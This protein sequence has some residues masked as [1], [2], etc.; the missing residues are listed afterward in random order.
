MAISVLIL[1][2]NEEQD[3][4]A[5]LDSIRWSTD[6]HVLDSFS[7]DRTVEI[8]QQAG[9]IVT[10]RRFDDW[11]TH[12]NWALLNLPFKF[13]WV[14][15][16]DADERVSSE[17][18]QNAN[19]QV[20]TSDPIS[21]FQIQR[22]DF[23]IDG[24]WLKHAQISPFYLRLF[25]PDK[26]RYE[27]LVNPVTIV[28]GP[29]RE[30]DGFLDHYPFSKGI[31]FWLERHINYSS[32]EASMIVDGQ[33]KTSS[34]SIFKG[35][36]TRDFTVRRYNQKAM[37]YKLPFRPLIK[38][39]YM[40]FWRRAFLDGKAGTTYAFL[41]SFYEYMIV[42]KERELQMKRLTKS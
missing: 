20:A 7:T 29:V 30:I 3:L 5:C 18:Q 34:I 25:R 8:A 36:L 17:L 28:D 27:R 22:R 16:I 37:F 39:S 21:A 4:P 24:K 11:S 35:L 31:G 1:T 6:I 15:Y 40:M 23:F 19:T 33:R 12:Q 2:K 41:Q 32:L 10:Q 26:I 9:C 14:L 42:L 38:F 13:P